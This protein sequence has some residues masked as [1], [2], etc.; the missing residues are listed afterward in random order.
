MKL[1][2]KTWWSIQ[3]L[4]LVRPL[5]VFGV[6]KFIEM[7]HF[8][9]HGGIGKILNLLNIISFWWIDVVWLLM[10]VGLFVTYT[11]KWVMCWMVVDLFFCWQGMFGRYK[12]SSSIASLKALRN[13]WTFNG[14]EL[15]T[16]DLTFYL[17]NW[18][19]LSNAFGN[20]SYISFIDSLI[21][22]DYNSLGDSFLQSVYLGF[23]SY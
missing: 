4:F 21:I 2:A 10:T 15:S 3:C 13:N 7:V 22:F 1:E 20:I 6:V 23:S 19:E 16:L 18:F 17:Y 12:K 8:L 14:I 9:F 5:G 11:V